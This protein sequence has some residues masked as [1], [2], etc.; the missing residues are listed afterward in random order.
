V[1]VPAITSTTDAAS[2]IL[3]RAV[4]V[5]VVAGVLAIGLAVGLLLVQGLLAAGPF[6]PGVVVRYGLPAARAAH[7]L[8]A[9]VSVGLLVL[10]A[11]C[12]APEPNDDPGRLSGVRLHA[13]RLAGIAVI[14]WLVLGIVALIFTA[15]D[16]SGFQPTT[17]GFS[18]VL[19]SF[20]TQI[21]LGRALGFSLLLVIVVGN[22]TLSATRITTVAWAAVLSIAALLPLALAGHAAGTSDHMNSVDSLALHLVGVCVWVGGLAGLLLIS[23]R[24]QTQRPVVVARYSTLAG[25]CFAL[26]ALSGL[27]NAGLR[28]GSWAALA[29]AYGL[30]VIGKAAALG[31]LGTAGFVHRR[32]TIARLSTA[33]RGFARLAVVEML[34]MGATLGL[35]VALSRSVPPAPEA[36][37]DPV[38]LLLGY[39]PPPPI[40]VGRYFTAF[41]PET[42][43]L[44]VALTFAG[45]YA[46]GVLRLRRRGDRWPAQRVLFWAAGC[47]A[48]I[49]VT[50]GGPA[51]YGRLHFSTHMVQHMT[52][53]V[54]VPLLLVFGA[55]LTLAMRAIPARTDGSF[56]PREMLLRMVHSR[57][58]RVLGHPIVAMV[59]FTGSL[60]IFY[61]SRLFELAMF[62]HTGHVLMTAHFLATG[63]LFIWSLVGLD[64]GP[65]RPPYPFRLVLLLMM[66]A[67]HAFFGIALMASTTLLAP[68]WW[69][70]LG[71]TD[72]V[73]LL[74]DQQNGGAIAWAAGDIPS[75]FLAV[76][77]LVGWV[78]SDASES[79]RLDRQADRDGD[80]ALRRYNSQLADLNRR[81]DQP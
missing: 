18:G 3:P 57:A 79:R 10:A 76:A 50:S 67:F 71:Q 26:V 8:A 81:N 72:D 61:Y 36:Q 41:Y 58:L 20:V 46:A 69:H 19:V 39:P 24:L 38:A 12:V 11:W 48:L 73:V 29:S 44:A 66:L 42:L 70:A 56:G 49:F 17:P 14:V 32:I 77:L 7:D 6:D 47:L 25:W 60:S 30:L 68:D 63:Y 78:R 21:D 65:A 59:L 13:V 52:L 43:W 45:L 37:V 62:T 74:D 40:S 64:P 53:M 2:R 16:V 23:N 31:M 80:A 27:I 51:V 28:L 1:T 22:L 35:A 4:L 9:A 55:P 54:L 75:L 15:S 33:P 34:I 5:V